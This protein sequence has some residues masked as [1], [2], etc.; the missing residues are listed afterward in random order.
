MCG[1]T[2]LIDRTGLS[3]VKLTHMVEAMGQAIA[4]R[5]PDGDGFWVD[6][7][8]GVAFAH[9][10]LAILGLGPNGAQPMASGDGRWIICYNGEVYN[11]QKLKEHRALAGVKWRGNSDTEAIVES[12]AHRGLPVTLNEMNGMFAFAL[13]DRHER[14]LHLVRDRHGI[15]PLY[16]KIEPN[17]VLFGSELKALRAAGANFEINRE[18]LASYLRLAYVPDYHSI[19]TGVSKLGPGEVLTISHDTSIERY[20]FSNASEVAIAGLADLFAGSDMEAEETL[21]N[22]LL[23][24]VRSQLISEV[25]LGVFLSGG[26]DSAI[27]AALAS[28]N[29]DIVK[30]FS[31]GFEDARF[32]ESTH[33]EAVARHLGTIHTTL[34]VTFE[35][36]LEVVPQLPELYDEPFADSSQIPTHLVSRMSRSAVSVA[37]SGDGGD[38]LF[39]GYT[40][41]VFAAE[42][43]PALARWPMPIRRAV[44]AM[45][46][47]LPRRSLDELSTHLP[48][49]PTLLGL[50]I[51]KLSRALTLDPDGLYRH[52]VSQIA[53]PSAH[54]EAEECAPVSLAEGPTSLLDQMRLSDML[55]Y[56]PGD[57]LTKV[58]RASMAVGLEVRPPFLDNN[59]V[60]FAWRLPQHLLVQNG[61]SKWILRRVLDRYIPPEL[62]ERPKQ[63]FGV[64]LGDWLRG[65]L[66]EFA[67]DLIEGYEYGGGFLRPDPARK[68]FR[69][70]ISGQ[71]SHEYALWTLLM[72]EAWRRSWFTT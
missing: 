72:F 26:L 24:A 32:D 40:R 4:H 70:H 8:T 48:S 68:L 30:T 39:A 20:S 36:A 35:D 31:I 9:R 62:T 19:F 54:I 58:D 71:A 14:R 44:A 59:V 51:E 12:I 16:F 11:F 41:H 5:G 37:L 61:R 18:A 64:P 43:W 29:S 22:L 57:I 23:N 33:A 42:R 15:K 7:A 10:R 13:F 50:K 45:L 67:G 53:N 28:A 6:A 46:G 47:Q 69:E 56:L 38:E 66:K 34:T 27:I 60:E 25:P 63:G 55:G 65:P 17:R 1:I 49:L 21:H 2:G 52:L 3:E